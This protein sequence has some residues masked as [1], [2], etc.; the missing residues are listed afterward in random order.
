LNV[1]IDAL[2]TDDDDDRDA[3]RVAL[4]NASSVGA[5]VAVGQS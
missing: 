4:R 2:L 5:S 1:S 3:A